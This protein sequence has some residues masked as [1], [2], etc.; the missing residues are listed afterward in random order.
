MFRIDR[1][2]VNLAT[3]RSVRVD[4]EEAEAG[5]AG[6]PLNAPASAAYVT[7]DMIKKA[8]ERAAAIIEEARE[9]AGLLILTAREEIEEEHRRAWQEGYAE[10]AEEGK[11]VVTEEFDKKKREY[12]E[13]VRRD[14]EMLSRIIGE[15]YT[16]RDNTYA[17]LE[18][19]IIGL[20]LEIVRKVINPAEEALGGVFESLIR[21]ALKQIAPEG[22]IIIRVSPAEYERFFSSGSAIFRLDKGATVTVA[23]LKDVS[24]G[25]NDCVIDTEDETVNAGLDT[26]LKYI[27]IAFNRAND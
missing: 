7:D 8:E 4:G 17:G 26:Q 16:E 22:K 11:R 13:K 25:D 9:N 14:D 12:D 10:G 23:V 19:E 2:L 6:Y 24:L 15:L 20:T 3:A 27:R 18:D 5:A 1:D 21:N